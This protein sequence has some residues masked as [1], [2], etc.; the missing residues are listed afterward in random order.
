MVDP[1][2]RLLTELEVCQTLGISK[3]TLR[4]MI[5]RGEFPEPLKLSSGTSRWPEQ[6]VNDYVDRLP[7]RNGPA[8]VD[9]KLRL[10]TGS[11]DGA[12]RKEVNEHPAHDYG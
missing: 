6:D 2:P 9:A 4:P 1:L 5:R 11:N 8:G 12:A 10:S 3:S 7:R